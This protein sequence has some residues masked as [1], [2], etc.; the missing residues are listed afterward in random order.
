MQIYL[1]GRT[2]TLDVDS[3]NTIDNVTR[4]IEYME[5]FPKVQQCI[6][7]NK[8]LDDNRTLADQNIWKESTVL[9]MLQQYPRGTEDL[10]EDVGRNYHHS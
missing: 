8:Q 10:R 4:K 5:W 2:I 3:S 6:F 7:A 9:L 1:A